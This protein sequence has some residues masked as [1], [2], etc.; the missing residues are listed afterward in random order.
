MVY[1]M[2]LRVCFLWLILAVWPS[3][4]GW[5]QQERYELGKRLRR[6]EIAWQQADSAGRAAAV[7]PMQKA[8]ESFFRFQLG[9]A[10]K[11]LDEAYFASLSTSKIS[12]FQRLVIAQRLEVQPVALDQ[13]RSNVQLKLKP[14]YPAD[15]PADGLGP[16][17]ESSEMR[18]AI[19]DPRGQAQARLTCQGVRLV[20]GMEWSIEGLNEGDYHL[21]LRAT[22]AM[23][24]WRFRTCSYLS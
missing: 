3:A 21:E 11:H 13:A 1:R 6:M 17:L 16:S 4:T 9:Q 20:E 8:V 23:S 19:L 22:T 5:T 15:T 14:V 2:A 10:T 7:K 24:Q 12:D 18:L